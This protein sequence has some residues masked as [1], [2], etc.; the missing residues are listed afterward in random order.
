VLTVASAR[1]NVVNFRGGMFARGDAG[2][3]QP[4]FPFT[5]DCLL[6]GGPAVI[7]VFQ[8]H[9]GPKPAEQ[10]N[11]RRSADMSAARRRGG[12][13]V[14]GG[15]RLGGGDCLLVI[16][17]VNCVPFRNCPFT[18]DFGWLART[19]RYR[20]N[21][22]RVRC[23]HRTMTGQN[24]RKPWPAWDCGAANLGRAS[25]CW[26]TD[27]DEDLATHRPP[28]KIKVTTRL[29]GSCPASILFGMVRS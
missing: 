27:I 5:I 7:P 20:E 23:L 24:A 26:S 3:A 19:V 9:W 17:L 10:P 22:V 2:S 1:V 28:P 18:C 14:N 13:V 4:S 12:C 6:S 11:R 29:I 21:T 8:P 15:E 16:S 25:A